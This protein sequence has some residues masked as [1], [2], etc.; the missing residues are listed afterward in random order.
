MGLLK[1]LR[2]PFAGAHARR[3]AAQL[4]RAIEGLGE[5]VPV[6]VVAYNNGTHVRGMVAQL[7]ARGLPAVVI[8]NAS[9]DPATRA[10][11]DEVEREGTARVVRGSGNLG[12]MVGFQQAVWDVLPRRFCYTDP[13]IRFDPAMPAD[14]LDTLS[15]LQERF[16]VFKVGLALS[17]DAAA[18]DESLR[19]RVRSHRPV[20][21]AM[22]VGIRDWESRF[23]RQ[24]LAC[25]GLEVYAA[26]VD[27]T[28][29]L[30]DKTRYRGSFTDA[31]RVAGPYA[32]VHLPWFPD[33]DPMREA[34]RQRYGQGNVC[35]TWR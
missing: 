20:R 31:V 27:T 2:K 8:D 19:A 10:L 9:T 6:L 32:A 33:L 5:R 4:A 15:S 16:D 34:E 29:A 35:N 12:H 28:F 30:Y 21:L 26:P 1:E 11:L 3:V 18:L 25:E 13:D 17:L 23:W 22:D 24:R 14:F 7:H